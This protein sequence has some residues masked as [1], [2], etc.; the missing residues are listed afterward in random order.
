MHMLKIMTLLSSIPKLS[1]WYLLFEKSILSFGKLNFGRGFGLSLMH[2]MYQD[3]GEFFRNLCD[4]LTDFEQGISVDITLNSWE[5]LTTNDTRGLWICGIKPS[6]NTKDEF[7][8]AA[9]QFYDSEE[10]TVVLVLCRYQFYCF[11]AFYLLRFLYFTYFGDF[12]Q[13]IFILHPVLT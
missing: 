1:K 6:V 11:S 2:L 3:Q 12:Y 4:T 5:H 10:F 7:T 13:W 8:N 9:N